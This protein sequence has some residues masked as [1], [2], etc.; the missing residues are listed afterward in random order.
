MNLVK[1]P[2]KLLQ[3]EGSLVILITKS[4]GKQL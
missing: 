3:A 1:D 4:L 2:E